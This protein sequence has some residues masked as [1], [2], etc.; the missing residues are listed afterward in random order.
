M[1]R[2]PMISRKRTDGTA[3]FVFRLL[4]IVMWMVMFGHSVFFPLAAAEENET[5]S[6]EW[7]GHLKTIG[8]I[9]WPD[10]KTIVDRDVDAPFYDGTFEG[11]LKNRVFWGN[12]FYTDIHYE[13]VVYGGDTRENMRFL[14]RIGGGYLG[15]GTINDDRRLLGLTGVIEEEDDHIWYHRLDRLSL[16]WVPDWGTVVAGRQALT[17]GNGLIFNAMDLFN[18]FAPTDINRDYKIGDDMLSVQFPVSGLG[19]VQWLI[20][21]RRNIESHD[22]EWNASSMAG[23]LHFFKGVTEFDIMAARHYK[24]YV[25]GL[26][27]MGYFGNA[28]WRADITCTYLDEQDRT[29]FALTANM[30]YSW[31]WFEK[32]FYGVVEFYYNGFGDTSYADADADPALTERLARGELYTLGRAYMA[33]KLQF[34][35]HP[36]INL[37]LTLINNIED[38]SGSIQPWLAWDVTEDIRLITGANLFYG[39]DNT[40]FGGYRPAHSPIYIKPANSVFAW[41][42][43]FF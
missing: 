38:P 23:K 4:W 39:A 12:K 25:I 33:G 10:D 16:T 7:G 42:T 9:S 5:I 32:N 11:R 20:V 29:V 18:P 37:Y 27:G 19:D 28:A 3:V 41:V 40:E 26:G 14:K 31:V 2:S 30:D 15:G 1:G 34:E 21:P 8:E 6:V 36:L 17:W 13:N 35:V 43:W 22:I 24:D